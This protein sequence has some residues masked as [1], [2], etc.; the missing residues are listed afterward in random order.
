MITPV[1]RARL[2]LSLPF[3]VVAAPSP[4][5]PPSSP[6]SSPSSRN[7]IALVSPMA[8]SAASPESAPPSSSS[9]TP[10]PTSQTRLLV[11]AIVAANPGA[12]VRIIDARTRLLHT[13]DRDGVRT[14]H[15]HKLF[16]D[17]DDAERAAVA[18]YLATGC[19]RA[20]AVVDAV[21]R[22]Q[23]FLLDFT[24]DPLPPDAHVG[25]THDL[26][27]IRDDVSRAYFDSALTA[28]IT[29]ASPPRG[30]KKVRRSITYGTYDHRERRIAIHPALDDADVPVLV[31]ARVVHH[32]LL[33][34]K[35]GED[36]D[37]HGRRVLHSNAFRADEALFIGAAEADAWLDRN[38]ER[39]LA[40]R[41][42]RR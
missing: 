22:R 3:D 9:S 24:A 41:P 7:T 16:L 19:R 38:L 33:H 11:D 5:P 42:P 32:E 39:M 20:G 4:P 23:R 14:F 35:H 13:T 27:V 18:R 2:Q 15:V 40:W 30:G 28:G 21:I 1:M 6:S 26:A 29:W 31:V 10:R 8:S 34:A 12:R 37:E 25:R 17:T 36:T